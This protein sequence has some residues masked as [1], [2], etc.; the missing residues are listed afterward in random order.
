MKKL[1]AVVLVGIMI[2]SLVACGGNDGGTENAEKTSDTPASDSAT[3]ADFDKL[4]AD[5]Q[6]KTAED[7]VKEYFADKAN[8]TAEEFAKL[9]ENY[10]FVDAN[11]EYEYDDN[12]VKQA[13]KLIKDG[14]AKVINEYNTDV[15]TYL[16]NSKYDGARAFIYRYQS[17]N[18]IDA[19]ASVYTPL[20]EK[21]MTETEPFVVYS[22]IRGLPQSYGNNETFWNFALSH[23]KDE[24]AN[25]RR[26]VA[27]AFDRFDMDNKDAAVETAITLMTDADE[28]VKQ[29]ALRYSG[30][31]GDDR[32]IDAY[33]AVLTD[34]AQAK[35]FHGNALLGLIDIWYGYPT[36]E[37]TSEAA[38]RLTMEYLSTETANPDI[39]SWNGMTGFKMKGSPSKYDEWRAAATYF[40][41]R[42]VAA[43]MLSIVSDAE[44]SRNVKSS[45]I[46]MIAAWGTL[47]DAQAAKAAVEALPDDNNDKSSLVSKCESA[48]AKLSK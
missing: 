39:P 16:I 13:V 7:L 46:D 29:N 9:Y 23:A 40:D 17:S 11:E 1:W 37:N 35:K 48:I 45:A 47:E 8:P 30:S 31:I 21:A 36:H 2:L 28:D 3:V 20:L 41:E 14:G 44:A 27:I 4:K 10:A 22:V 24:D 42:E 15:I 12:T 43:V 5:F 34:E 18:N 19:G 6:K 38:Y 26:A 25:V 33:K 32:L